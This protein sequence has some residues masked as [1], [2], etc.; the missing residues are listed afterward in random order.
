MTRPKEPVGDANARV[1]NDE[2]ACRSARSERR[3]W[4]SPLAR[5]GQGVRGRRHGSS[6]SERKEPALTKG[7]QTIVRGDND[8]RSG[9][10]VHRLDPCQ[11]DVG[12]DKA[13][14]GAV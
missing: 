14:V 9:A 13:K 4:R 7:S 10:V 2:S 5:F 8:Q 3:V 1:Q 12:L 6:G 11:P